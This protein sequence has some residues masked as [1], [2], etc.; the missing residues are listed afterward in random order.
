MGKT[1]EKT[2]DQKLTEFQTF[3][4]ERRLS[5]N[6]ILSYCGSVRLYRS[7]YPA[8]SR[9]FLKQ[10]RGYLLGHYKPSTACQ[11]IHGINRFLE[12]Q[13]MPELR[14][15]PVRPRGVSFQDRVISDQDYRTLKRRLKKDGAEKWYFI[16]W[17]LGATGARVSEL[18]CFKAEHLPAGYMDL[19]SKGGKMRRIYFPESLR[20]EALP[21]LQEAGLNTGFI[22]TNRRG[23]P[24]TPRGIHSQ[25]KVLAKRYGIPEKTVYPH[26]FR[27]RF[28]I[29]FLDKFNDISLLA[30]LLGHDS[31][32]TTKIYLTK[33]SEE[34]RELIDS[35]V[36]W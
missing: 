11:R 4:R 33:S 13:N 22:F 3:L 25:L 29:N 12:Y 5:D 9:R 21:R 17:F 28:A 16:V 2:E 35:I 34:Q 8:I 31:V 27:H 14:L 19:Y 32:E 10:Y 24:I 6:T 1:K 23:A 26:A 18:L 20:R 36:T 30:D 15:A 7:L